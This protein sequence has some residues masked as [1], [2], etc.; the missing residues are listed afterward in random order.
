MSVYNGERWL[1]ESIKSVTDQTFK[2]YEFIIVNDGSNDCSLE[3]IRKHALLDDRLIVIDKP[4]T[5]LADSLNE[6]IKQAK[7]DWIARIDADDLCEP[8]RLQKQ[9]ELAHAY[10]DLVLIGTGLIEIDEA[11]RSGKVFLCPA[12]HAAILNRLTTVRPLFSHSSAFYKTDVVRKLG[13]YRPR[14]K[15]AQDWDLWLRLSAVGKIACIARPLVKIRRHPYQITN[16]EQGMRQIIDSRVA[17]TSYWLRCYGLIDPVS[18]STS[19]I[20][21]NKFREWVTQA[22]QQNRLFEYH[23]FVQIAKHNFFSNTI[24]GYSRLL[25]LIFKNP[26]FTFRYFKQFIVGERFQEKL[27]LEWAEMSQTNNGQTARRAGDR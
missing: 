19:D 7:G 4:N 1:A 6:G 25:N 9:Y 22:L 21:F 27:A 23:N 17:M 12:S 5:G 18:S 15:R 24:L 3:L 11:G 8:E 13:G 20:D 2:N 16:D 10:S 14:I 26:N